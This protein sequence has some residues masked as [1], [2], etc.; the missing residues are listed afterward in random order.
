M[1]E[2]TKYFKKREEKEAKR[3]GFQVDLDIFYI[4][5]NKITFHFIISTFFYQLDVSDLINQ[6]FINRLNF[7]DDFLS[8]LGNWLFVLLVFV[9]LDFVL[10]P[11]DFWVTKFAQMMPMKMHFIV[12]PCQHRRFTTT[13]TFEAHSFCHM[14]HFHM[15]LQIPFVIDLLFAYIASEWLKINKKY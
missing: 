12:L 14:V 7:Y 4:F 1:H 10:A 5:K 2:E 11:N 13:T 6:R 9:L 15:A 8:W 3:T